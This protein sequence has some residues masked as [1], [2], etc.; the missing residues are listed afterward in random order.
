[1]SSDS[2]SDYTSYYLDDKK[3]E[4][5]QDFI[6]KDEVKVQKKAK[7]ILKTFKVTSIFLLALLAVFSFTNAPIYLSD[8]LLKLSGFNA[9]IRESVD[10]KD[11][12]VKQFLSIL[13]SSNEAEQRSRE[14][15]LKPHLA[16]HD[17]FDSNTSAITY[18]T[19]KFNEYGLETYNE[20]YN[21]TLNT[22]VKTGLKLFK[23]GNYGNSS[24][25]ELIYDAP[26]MEDEL[27]IDP[28]PETEIYKGGWHGLSKNGTVKSS[29]YVFT[30]YGT[31][32]D[33]ELLSKNNV[34]TEGAICISKYGNIY[35]GLKV[36]FAQEIGKC[37]AVVLYTD[38]GDDY[39][40]A[41]DGYK[42]YPD[43]PA[44]NPSSIQ[45]GSVLFLSD[46]QEN[47]DDFTDIIPKIPSIPVSY[48]AIQPILKT[49]NGYGLSCS[50]LE[51]SSG[52]GWCSG[53]IE[54]VDYSTGPVPATEGFEL[55][56][57]NIQDYNQ[58]E[59]VDVLGNLTI[60]AGSPKTERGYIVIG[61]HRDTWV[62][63][64]ADPESGTTVILEILRVLKELKD[65]FSWAPKTDIVFASWDAEEYG[66][67]GS[68][69]FVSNHSK[70]LKSNAL[71]YLNVDV[72]VSGSNLSI[73]SSPLLNEII[74]S[75]L[76][77]VEYP[78]DKSQNLFDHYFGS[79]ERFSSLGSGSDYTAFYEHAGIPSLDI[80]FGSGEGDPVYHYHSNYDSFYWMSQM[81]DPG[82]E[83]HNAIAK[84]LGGILLELSENELIQ[85][86]TTE[87]LSLIDSFFVDIADNVPEDWFSYVPAFNKHTTGAKKCH[88]SKKTHGKKH[89]DDEF[90]KKEHHG[91][92]HD[93]EE[94]EKKEH[95]GKKH[96]DEEFEKKEHHGKK[97][98][99]EEFE[100]KEHHGK[101]HD[102]EEFEKKE[103]HG[104]KHDDEEFE[105][106]E[107]HGK[108][109]DDEKADK[110]ENHGKKHDE[111][112]FEKKEHHGKKHDDGE[113]EKKEHHGKKHDDEEFEKKEHHGKK[114]DDDEFEKKEHHGKKHDDEE[115]EKKEHHG[116]K[117]DDEEFEKK[118]HH[119]KKHDD[120]E[121][122][123]K[124]HHGKKHDDEKA[125]K[126][127]NHG[128][129]HDEEEFEKKEHHGKK[130]DGEFEKKKYHGK[131]HPS[132]SLIDLMNLTYDNILAYKDKA[133]KIDA[134]SDDLTLSLKN[135]DWLPFW[136][137]IA[138]NYK[139]LGQNM[140]LK[141]FERHFLDKKGLTGRP[142]FKHAIYAA[143]KNYGY[144]SNEL[145]GLQDALDVKDVADFYHWLN[146]LNEMFKI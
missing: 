108:K 70:D 90:E 4:L 1:M 75:I 83:Y 29:K 61:A 78:K 6:F 93:D 131:K 96:D 35:R 58:R 127:E 37:A 42:S 91:K 87:Y 101:K 107:H 24:T 55:E 11:F 80:G 2:D 45:R 114:H 99:D 32:K 76:V 95:H 79:N 97:H 140:K 53:V 30:N 51:A 121:F 59:I 139:I 27:D 44:R 9:D 84:V 138:L 60:G 5:D 123:K 48:A 63:G 119:G 116:K 69:L 33:Y 54:G 86:K 133:L 102:D 111:E 23:S 8:F 106:K 129:K 120:E 47:V 92:K 49:L 3:E 100:K 72:S 65:T 110:K 10:N 113:F 128:K 66:L 146:V 109:H 64:G 137:R 17:N 25:S 62:S 81:Q 143:G 130:H 15:T 46:L 13:S 104:K 124:E 18:I 134:K 126:K 28:F 142:F 38:P 14:L 132:L 145:P 50:Q 67:I 88:M 144:A 103:H 52:S 19:K 135:Y 16:G 118:E 117:H 43:G 74:K 31:L 89:D 7:K 26:L 141:Y 36:K 21:V 94:F 40:K 71:A 85:F 68:N 122:E 77:Q 34:S 20:T 105:K 12:I 98:D 39:Y 73:G 41:V 115:F 22:P 56:V 136:E 112:E 57:E 82:F 125:D